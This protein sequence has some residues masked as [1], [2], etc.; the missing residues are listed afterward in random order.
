MGFNMKKKTFSY[1]KKKFE[2]QFYKK[3]CWLTCSMYFLT[4][5]RWATFS[6]VETLQISHKT[7]SCSKCV[8]NESWA[9]KEKCGAYRPQNTPSTRCCCHLFTSL[10]HKNCWRV[11]LLCLQEIYN[12]SNFNMNSLIIAHSLKLMARWTKN[13]SIKQHYHIL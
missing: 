13:I 12:N 8:S 9:N 2:T 10:L 3:N 4:S 6:C 7:N 1:L 11:Q 5:T